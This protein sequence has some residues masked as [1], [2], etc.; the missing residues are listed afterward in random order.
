MQLQYALDLSHIETLSIL[1]NAVPT[2][3]FEH[4]H[5]IDLN[6]ACAKVI[7]YSR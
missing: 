1:A 4:E 5:I 2:A 3:Q 7:M 6:V